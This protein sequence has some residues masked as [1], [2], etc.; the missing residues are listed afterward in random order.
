VPPPTPDDRAK[1]FRIFTKDMP[2]GDDVDIEELAAWTPG[3][4]GADIETMCREAAIRALRADIHADIIHK[5]H[6]ESALTGIHPSASPEIVK[7]YND[8]EEKLKARKPG[9][10]GSEGPSNLFL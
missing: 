3:F 8:F 9:S 10:R 2:L 7:W 5:D 1:I 6:F 4:T